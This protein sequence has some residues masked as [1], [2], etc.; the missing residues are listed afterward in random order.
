[1]ILHEMCEQISI[2]AEDLIPTTIKL[3]IIT[4]QELQPREGL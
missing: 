1:M 3:E 2:S 4:K